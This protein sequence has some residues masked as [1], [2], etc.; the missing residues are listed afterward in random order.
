MDH[1]KNHNIGRADILKRLIRTIICIIAFA[2]VRILLHAIVFL[3]FIFLLVLT[4]H[5]EPL[6]SLGNK[7]T[8]YA[9]ELL[10]Y[11]TLNGNRRPFPFSNLPA[12][13]ECERPTSD[14]DYS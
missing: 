9:Y 10:R 14:I 2:L 6:R 5:N 3:Q 11:S 7:L 13:N 1:Q 4:K 12:D 8:T